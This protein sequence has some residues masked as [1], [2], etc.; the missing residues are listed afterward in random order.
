L[1]ELLKTARSGIAELFAIQK[2]AIGS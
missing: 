1:A 2:Q